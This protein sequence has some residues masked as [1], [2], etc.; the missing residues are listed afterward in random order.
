[1][2]RNEYLRHHRI[3]RNWR[4]G[5]VARQLDIPLSTLQRWERG[6]HHPSAYYRAKLC[7]L[8][9]L[10]PQELGLVEEAQPPQEETDEKPQPPEPVPEPA[11]WTVPHTR[12]PHFTGRESY[13]E[14]IIH[15]FSQTARELLTDQVRVPQAYVLK[16]LGGIGKTQIAVE[17]AYRAHEQKRYVHTLWIMAA[18]QE[19]ILT[20]FTALADL[21]PALPSRG[22]T[23]QQKLVTMVI[24]WLERC[25]QPWLLIVDN[26]DNPSLVH[27]YLPRLGNGCILLTTRASAVN[28]FATSLEVDNMSITEAT[29]FLLRRA[30][31]NWT[32]L[33]P[34]ER[35]KTT[36]HVVALAQFPL[37]L[38]Q[39]GAY[40]EET[41]CR[42]STYF[43][44]YQESRQRLLARR[45]TQITHYPESVATT[46]S[47]AFE[48]IEQVNQAAAELLQ[49]CTFCVPD[50]IPEELLIKGAP[51]WPPLLKEAVTDLFRFNQIM[52]TLLT[53]SLVKRQ[54]EDSSLSLHR[55]V[56]AIQM[57]RMSALK[58]RQWA[59]R[60]VGVVNT[61]FPSGRNA[62]TWHQCRRYLT[63]VE[64][65]SSLIEQW[66]LISPEAGRLLHQAG[67]YANIHAQYAQAEQWLTQA[68]AIHQQV[69]GTE[70][71]QVAESL[72]SLAMLYQTLGRYEEAEP[73]FLRALS[74]GEHQ[75]G[76]E[77][78]A[79]ASYLN[80]LGMMYKSRGR[81]EEA[82]PLFLRALSIG[83]HQWG[84]EHPAIAIYLNNLATIYGLRGRYEEAEPLFL[85]ALSIGEHQLGTEHPRVAG[86][87]TDLAKVY[88]LRGKYEEAE[89]LF[90]RALS[91]GEHQWGTEHPQVAEC[92]HSLARLYTHQGKYEEAE[93]LLQRALQIQAC[94]LSP[95]H[96]QVAESL[97]SL[98]LLSRNQGKDTEAELIYQ[99]V[100]S[101]RE[102][103]LGQH[104]PETAQTL[105]DL[106]VFREKQGN[107][108]EA[109]IQAQR[110]LAIRSHALGDVH[111][112]TVATQALYDQLLQKP[113]CAEGETTSRQRGEGTLEPRRETDGVNRYGHIL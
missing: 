22:E 98:A 10:S 28:L 48:S 19:S 51:H 110:A 106:A 103:H 33:S 104:H 42:F 86:F 34:T 8:F 12:N 24:K 96:P 54:I 109:L 88:E 63:Y 11:L 108:G 93:P 57:E 77:H 69:Q 105:H 35:E 81:Y 90:L 41:R 29:T 31:R 61:L 113:V 20:S 49:L 82:E 78:P 21:L 13:L 16:G 74:I 7:T 15:L 107:R 43:Q 56:Q 38:D 70:H 44:L 58:Q 37:A 62:E 83:E 23:N 2:T 95:D 64:V 84:A 27:P 75:L 47:L 45:G 50:S 101:I 18:S 71:P 65:C 112:K 97:N 55:L 73:L 72:N 52:E 102:Q 66:K 3:L 79:I 100:L 25:P 92:L 6:V 9:D 87:L 26:A 14:Q 59:E 85:R 91:I 46:W 36:Q 30:D 32:D 60:L 99:R 111:P 94:A 76:T 4:Q 17:Y 1:M 89:P 40:I 68:C 53:F 67:I 5:D 80:S 39:A